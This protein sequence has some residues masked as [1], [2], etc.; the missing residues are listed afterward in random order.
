MILSIIALILSYILGAIPFAY[1][2]V[3]GIKGIDIRNQGSGN[4]G[5]T[6]ALRLIGWGPGLLVLIADM[7]KGAI[8]VLFI[9]RLGLIQQNALSVYMPVICGFSAIIGHIWTVFLKFRGGKGVATSLGI[10]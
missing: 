6:N 10:F 9:S 8:A 7:A 2:I 4:V 3:K 1:I 5:F